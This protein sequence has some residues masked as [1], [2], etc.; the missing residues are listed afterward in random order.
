MSL[1]DSFG[2]VCWQRRCFA[3][4]SAVISCLVD[5]ALVLDLKWK[6]KFTDQL[7]CLNRCQG[8]KHRKVSVRH[9]VFPSFLI[10]SRFWVV[11]GGGRPLLRCTYTKWRAQA[12]HEILV[13]T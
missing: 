7:L 9:Q 4:R 3:G 12:F 8:E 13:R 6:E 1:N 5:R 10:P 11:F 2:N